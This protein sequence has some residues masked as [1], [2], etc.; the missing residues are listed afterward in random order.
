MKTLTIGNTT[1]N[2]AYLIRL[3]YKAR[4]KNIVPSPKSK[5]P[6]LTKIQTSASSLEIHFLDCDMIHFKNDEA[7]ALW[8]RLSALLEL[9]PGAPPRGGNFHPLLNRASRCPHPSAAS[10]SRNSRP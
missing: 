8:S 10:S 1:Y 3:K 4:T 9:D 6:A 5:N 2:L 7:D